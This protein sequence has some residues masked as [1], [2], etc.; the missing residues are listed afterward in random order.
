MLI[1]TTWRKENSWPVGNRIQLFGISCDLSLFMPYT[2]PAPSIIRIIRSRRMI[3]AKHVVRMGEK[4]NAYI[5]G[6][7]RRKDATRKTKT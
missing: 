3:W 7:A 2:I 5:C 6:N 1:S 4:R